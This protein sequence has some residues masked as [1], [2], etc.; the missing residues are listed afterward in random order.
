MNY[1]YKDRDIELISAYIDSQLSPAENNAVKARLQ[2]DANF[3]QLLRDLTYA[4]SL[5]H[6]LPQKRAPRNFTLS[7]EYAHAP[8]RALWLQ[9]AMSFVSV[10][11]AVALVVLFASTYLLGGPRQAVTEAPAPE[12]AE[13]FAMEEAVDAV[14]PPIINWNPVYGMGGGG[15]EEPYAGG[16]GGGGAGGPGWDVSAPVVES[17]PVATES[18]VEELPMEPT[19]LPEGARVTEEAPLTAP[20][21]P[22]SE[23]PAI[24]SA[25]GDDLSTMILGLPEADAQGQVISTSA[26]ESLD[27]GRA[28]KALP[29]NLLMIVSAIIAALAGVAAILLRRR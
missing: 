16:I 6:A 11:A 5:L 24:K 10:A 12:A 21:E 23:A 2:S 1:Q 9:P 27:Q 28:G 18:P 14:S 17:E 8:R 3:V 13:M 15:A 29:A 4:R 19:P 26:D 20:V 7:A 22:G 25:G